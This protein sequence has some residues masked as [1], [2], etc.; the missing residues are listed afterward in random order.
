[1]LTNKEI[2]RAKQNVAIKNAIMEEFAKGCFSM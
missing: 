2:H 1:M